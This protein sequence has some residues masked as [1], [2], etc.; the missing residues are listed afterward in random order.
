M[1][2]TNAGKC[3]PHFERDRGRNSRWLTMLFCSQSELPQLLLGRSCVGRL[4]HVSAS[5][6]RTRPAPP[7]LS[8]LPKTLPL[9][10]RKCT[11]GAGRASDSLIVVI[12]C[13][14]VI[15]QPVLDSEPGGRTCEKDR[16]WTA[17]R[18]RE[19]THH[20]H[21]SRKLTHRRAF[22]TRRNAPPKRQ[23]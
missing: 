17:C 3:V 13:A 7:A 20:F 4:F 1:A 23:R 10:L 2:D 15:V 18:A 14:F 5:C 19:F 6:Y 22:L 12:G 16:A 11:A 8:L 21:G 9:R